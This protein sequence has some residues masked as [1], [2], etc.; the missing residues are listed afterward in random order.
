MDKER[1]ACSRMNFYVKIVSTLSTIAA[2]PGIWSDAVL[3][4]LG[5][6]YSALTALTKYFIIK[7]G[8]YNQPLHS[9]RYI[10]KK[11][12]AYLIFC[13]NTM[14]FLLSCCR[15][16]KTVRLAD[17]ELSKNMYCFTEHVI[18]DGGG[19]TKGGTEKAKKKDP[20]L[21]KNKVL[22]E[23]KII[24][25]VIYEKEQ[26]NKF[27]LQLSNKSKSNLAGKTKQSMARDYRLFAK[28]VREIL[29][30]ENTQNDVSVIFCF[31]MQ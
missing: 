7:V 3:R 17:G 15:F 25:R 18:S 13:K 4:E 21:L 16:E 31:I 29:E 19:K 5:N 8:R 26:F 22:K 6:V 28:Q 23:T 2:P 12:L 14:R 9:T 20:N 11:N 10:R 30:N 24:P 27:I 1:E